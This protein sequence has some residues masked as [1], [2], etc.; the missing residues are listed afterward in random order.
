MNSVLA[1]TYSAVYL[2]VRHIF[3]DIPPA[4]ARSALRSNAIG[5][6]LDAQYRARVRL[7]GGGLAAHRRSQVFLALVQAIW[8]R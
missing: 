2:A 3:P 4:R 1:T 6:F 8:T 5:T 7:R